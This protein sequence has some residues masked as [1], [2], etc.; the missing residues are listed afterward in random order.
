[1]SKRQR[2]KKDAIWAGVYVTRGKAAKN[3]AF[4]WRFLEY[5]TKHMPAQPFAGPAAERARSTYRSDIAAEVK[6]QVLKQLEIRAKRQRA[7]K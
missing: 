5:G 3:D 6:R 2:G 1:M 7:G 4:Y